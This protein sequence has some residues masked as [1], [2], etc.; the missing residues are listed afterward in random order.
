LVLVGLGGGG[1]SSIGLDWCSRACRADEQVMRCERV[2]GG[3]GPG[4]YLFGHFL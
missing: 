2:G 4:I 3:G 1:G